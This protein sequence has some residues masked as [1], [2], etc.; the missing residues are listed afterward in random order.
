MSGKASTWTH[1]RLHLAT[2][3][4]STSCLPAVLDRADVV[5]VPTSQAGEEAHPQGPSSVARTQDSDPPPSTSS[6]QPHS[7]ALVG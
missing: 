2:A 1:A 6:P 4:T 7:P 3:F 5:A